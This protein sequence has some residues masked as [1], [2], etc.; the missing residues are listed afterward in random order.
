MNIV[1]S[2]CYAESGATG[3]GAN[4]MKNDKAKAEFASLWTYVKGIING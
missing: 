1:R 3:Q 2:V 4:E